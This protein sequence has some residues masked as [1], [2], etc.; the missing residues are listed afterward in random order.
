MRKI[1]STLLLLGI[2]ES[3]NE[4][5]ESG[6]SEGILLSLICMQK[7]VLGA[8]FHKTHISSGKGNDFVWSGTLDGVHKPL[9]VG[10]FIPLT[11]GG[12]QKD[13]TAWL[14]RFGG[15]FDFRCD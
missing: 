3:V 8:L 4:C 2:L 1:Q 14:K 6:P 11:L 15:C 10:L 5:V 13:G 9:K 12:N 7:V